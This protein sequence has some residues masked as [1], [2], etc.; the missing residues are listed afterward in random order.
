MQPQEYHHE[1]IIGYEIW[2]GPWGWKRTAV[3]CFSESEASQVW[4]ELT[5][6]K[7][8]GE[9]KIKTLK[10]MERTLLPWRD[11]TRRFDDQYLSKND[12]I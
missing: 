9:G 11:V 5:S 4:R 6:L 10:I 1:W 3:E 8:S 7:Y 2:T 12:E